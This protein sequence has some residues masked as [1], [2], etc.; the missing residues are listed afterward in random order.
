MNERLDR[1]LA[2]LRQWFAGLQPREQWLVSRGAVAA[3]L[4]LLVGG[5]LQL[6]GAVTAAKRAVERKQEDL[7]Y[8]VSHLDQLRA[9]GARTPDLETPLPALVERTA[10]DAGL[11]DQLKANQAEGNGTVRVKFE[12][13][14]FDTLV[15]WLSSLQQEQAVRVETATVDRAESGAVVAT[16]VLARG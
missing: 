3:A 12:G 9:A 6:H 8:I 15:L 16:L 4:L 13:V 10:R 14:A 7:A 5:A 2:P 1:W 11:G